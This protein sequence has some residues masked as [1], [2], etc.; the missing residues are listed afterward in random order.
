MA[1]EIFSENSMP[2]I[3]WGRHPQEAYDT[4]YEHE[5]QRQF[6]RECDALLREIIKRLRPH[7]LKYHRDEQ[8]LQK[9]TWL[10]TMDLLASLLDCVALLK[11][12]RHRPVARVFRDAVEAIDVMRFLHADSPKAVS[13][14]KKWYQ[15]ETIS[16]GEIRKLIEAQDGVEAATVRRVFYQELS[17][18]THR[19]YR[20]LLHSVSLGRD[21]LMVH[22]SHG[23]GHLVLPQTIAAYMAVLGDITIQAS[24]SVSFTGLLASDEVAEAWGAALEVHTV[25]RRF[26]MQVK[27]GSPL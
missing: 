22:D 15:N 8:S 3:V 9:A 26:A 14:L 23:S 11:E 12:M 17:K 27:P 13:A 5:A 25:P 20:A 10:I 2:S 18:F 19:T 6:L 21:D 1:I 24:G 16:H 7:T 4:P